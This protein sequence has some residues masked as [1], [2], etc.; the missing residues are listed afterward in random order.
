MSMID[1]LRK[2]FAG[3]V[4]KAS[5]H[6]NISG[7]AGSANNGTWIRV[8]A[9]DDKSGILPES[10]DDA[11]NGDTRSSRQRRNHTGIQ[12]QGGT[13]RRQGRSTLAQPAEHFDVQPNQIATQKAHLEGG[14]LR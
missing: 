10:G 1:A 11:A 8:S 4:E 3:D 6:C 14:G 12:G 9:Q 2:K 7:N 5:S 13:R